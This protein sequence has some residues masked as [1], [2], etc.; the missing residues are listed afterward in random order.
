MRPV[1]FDS[2]ALR[3]FL[4]RKK[5]ATLPEMKDALGTQVALTVFRKL[6]PMDYLTSY[7][8][9]G[10]YY[11]L[12]EI[13]DFDSDGLWSNNSAWFSSHGTL[14][15][16]AGEFVCASPGGYFADE[17]AQRLHVEVHDALLQLV[18][19]HQ[20]SR[21]VVS[22]AYL[23][24]AEASAL[25]RRQLLARRELPILPSAAVTTQQH[26]S[27]D[28]LNAAIVLF[29]ST[30]NEQ[31]RRLYVGLESLKI[32]H[33]G[34]RQLADLFG[35]DPHTV[36]RGRHE[37]LTKQVQIDRSRRSGGGRHAVEKKP[38]K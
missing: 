20:I 22:G 9:A 4:L 2:S 5:I 8:H 13:A 27:G 17:L 10:R 37:L 15:A 31:Q 18:E 11:T 3:Q 6:K 34:D 28:E 14:L 21:Q 7:S 36:A 33:G 32:G 25:R 1:Q 24:T 23:Y 19:Q 16:T 38:R 30:L 26:L 29:Y 12:R 35:L